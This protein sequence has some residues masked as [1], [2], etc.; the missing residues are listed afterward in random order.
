MVTA[1]LHLRAAA[2]AV[3]GF[4][5]VVVAAGGTFAA[6]NPA[7]LYSLGAGPPL[8]TAAGI[9]PRPAA[10][11][12]RRAWPPRALGGGPSSSFHA[13]RY[14]SPMV[15]RVTDREIR[16]VATYLS[17]GSCKA[18]A[19]R[20]GIRDETVRH[21]LGRAYSRHEV[22]GI[23]QLVWVARHELEAVVDGGEDGPRGA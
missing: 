2:T 4:V 6:S 20:L 11:G 21:R 1:H 19:A 9:L 5:V 18:A 16:L 15:V 22:S 23:A 12:P 17:A 8:T 13:G 3:A 14:G 10:S 7:T